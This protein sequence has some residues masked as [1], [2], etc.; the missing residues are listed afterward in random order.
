MDA[1]HAGDESAT[2]VVHDRSLIDHLIAIF[3]SDSREEPAAEPTEA[4]YHLIKR[5][6]PANLTLGI[7]R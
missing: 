4:A 5:E 2:Q 7:G 3:H 6:W 1:P